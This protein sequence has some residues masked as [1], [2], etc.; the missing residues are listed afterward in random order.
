VVQVGG[1]VIG[2]AADELQRAV[3]EE[4]T[5]SPAHVIIDISDVSRIDRRAIDVLASAAAIA[6]EADI[7]LG[8]V[9]LGGNP[10]RDAL[11]AANMTELFEVFETVDDA[12]QASRRPRQD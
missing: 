6:G 8:L 3:Y 7:S 4:L 11:A 9:D 2:V 10:V 5:G 1:D 12:V